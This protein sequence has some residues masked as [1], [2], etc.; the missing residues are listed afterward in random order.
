MDMDNALGVA[1]VLTETAVLVLL[2]YRR[3]WR[4]LPVF[5]AYCVWALASDGAAYGIRIL[6]PTSYGMRFYATE[7]VLDFSFQFSVLVELAWSVL[8]PLR[9][10]LSR[11]T[12]F[13][14]AAAILAV[15]AV[16]GP[17]AGIAGLKAPREWH[18]LFQ[19][20]QTVTILRVFFF[21]GLAGCSHVLS[22]NW[23]DRE[24]Q[25][26]TGFGFYSFVSLAVAALNTHQSSGLQ[27]THLYRVV[28][29][30]FLCSLLY[31]VFSFAQSGA[32]RQEFTPQ[33]QSTLMAMAENA[34]LIRGAL[35]DSAVARTQRPDVS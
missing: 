4:T 32:A 25:V 19:L 1:G 26:A 6:S 10:N 35:G 15:G 31:W 7:T 30:S 13:V 24:L 29:V 5:F 27:L 9:A 22:M 16:I 11:K 3:I 34:H 8:R 18:L 21:L 23:R 33:M 2:I 20:Q 14:V 17:F 28:V 12:L